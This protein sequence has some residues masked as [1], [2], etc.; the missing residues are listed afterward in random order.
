MIKITKDSLEYLGIKTV[1]IILNGGKRIIC[2][3]VKLYLDCWRVYIGFI[4]GIKENEFGSLEIL[5]TD[6]SKISIFCN[7]K[8][9]NNKYKQFLLLLK[10]PLPHSMQAAIKSLEEKYGQW[11]KRKGLR[12]KIGTDKCCA[13]G[14]RKKEQTLVLDGHDYNCIL[15]DVSMHGVRIKFKHLQPNSFQ[16]FSLSLLPAILGLKLYFAVPIFFMIEP[17]RIHNINEMTGEI[18]L[19]CKIKSPVSIAYINKVVKYSKKSEYKYVFEQSR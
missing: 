10:K 11:E 6:N 14:L 16:E 18:S 12:L 19:A 15:E 17:V 9:I 13:F 5:K 7:I 2:I 1:Y 4:D 8:R 3:P